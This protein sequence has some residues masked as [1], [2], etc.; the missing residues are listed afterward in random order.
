[1]NITPIDDHDLNR[2]I[3]RGIIAEMEAT[4][5]ESIPFPLRDYIDEVPLSK[6]VAA[7]KRGLGTV[8]TLMALVL[9]AAAWILMEQPI[10]WFVAH[11]HI[12]H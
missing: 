10:A 12:I 4:G 3:A 1:V 11:R 8:D 6:P 7:K 2:T 5:R 9:L